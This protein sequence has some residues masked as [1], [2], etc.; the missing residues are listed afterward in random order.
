MR[1]VSKRQTDGSCRLRQFTLPLTVAA[2]LGLSACGEPSSRM[3]ETRAEI[4][5]A[6]SSPVTPESASRSADRYVNSLT[7]EA[8]GDAEGSLRSD[9]AD[10]MLTGG[11]DENGFI[12][13]SFTR[14]KITDED[15]FQVRLVTGQ[16]VGAAGTGTFELSEVGWYDGTFKAEDLPTEVDIRIPDAYEGTGVLTLTTHEPAI[17]E[18][19]MAGTF[20]GRVE[21]VSGDNMATVRASFDINLSCSS[22]ALNR[23][24]KL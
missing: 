5:T 18:R 20:A 13:M 6:A 15:L 21:Q 17:N 19:R 10:I 22:A 12:R 14:G 1:M 4:A 3:A 23:M 8:E 9:G 2:A 16:S 7:F 24:K 11:C